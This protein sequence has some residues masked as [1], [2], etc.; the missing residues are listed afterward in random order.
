MIENTDV[1][2]PLAKVLLSMLPEGI[3]VSEDESDSPAVARRK[4]EI[5]DA[6]LRVFSTKGFDGGRTK[7]IAREAGTSEA[8]I[9]KYFP[10]KR[11]LMMGLIKPLMEMIGRPLFMK[12][13]E[14]LLERQK[15]RP[16]E[17]TLTLIMM[18]RWKL[19]TEKERMVSLAYMEAIRNPEMLEIFKQLIVPQVLK[20]LEPV[21]QEAADSGEIRSDLSS[22]LLSR[23]F[24]AQVLGFILLV[25]V[26]PENFAL[27]DVETDIAATVSIF[28]QGLRPT[29]GLKKEHSHGQH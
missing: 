23:S 24:L 13:I 3:A 4:K 29:N 8:T 26:N 18:D 22:R 27:S 28:V 5:L 19:F 11:H 12:P 25:R 10:T 2:A 7:D 9:F 6:S 21:F 14:R 1:D 20:Y 15:G 17:E 16:L